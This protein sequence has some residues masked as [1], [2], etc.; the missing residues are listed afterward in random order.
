MRNLK[1]GVQ[2]SRQQGETMNYFV[3]IKNQIFFV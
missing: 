3:F 2:T 1:I